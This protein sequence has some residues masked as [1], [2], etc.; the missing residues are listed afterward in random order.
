MVNTLFLQSEMQDPYQFYKKMLYENPVF[1]D[2]SNNIWA[3]YS[4]RNCKAA[5]LDPAVLIPPLNQNNTNNL[6][7]CALAIDGRLARISSHNSMLLT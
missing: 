7:E 5:L 1:W 6:N 2:S 3:I 4:Y